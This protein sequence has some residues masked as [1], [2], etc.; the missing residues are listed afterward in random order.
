MLERPVPYGDAFPGDLTAREQEHGAPCSPHIKAAF[1]NR[2]LS[3]EQ[4]QSSAHGLLTMTM[5]FGAAWLYYQNDAPEAMRGWVSLF[6]VMT[7]V[8]GLWFT[9]YRFRKAALQ[10]AHDLGMNDTQVQQEMQRYA[11]NDEPL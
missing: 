8:G 2:M 3:F 7:L 1:S 10:T 5:L 6:L 11:T 4:E 9:R